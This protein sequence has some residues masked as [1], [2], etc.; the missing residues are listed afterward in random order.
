M[1][2]PRDTVHVAGRVRDADQVD[3]VDGVEDPGVVAAHHPDADEAEA[4]VAII[5]HLPWR[6]R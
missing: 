2:S 6:G 4:H 3:A 5:R 1:A